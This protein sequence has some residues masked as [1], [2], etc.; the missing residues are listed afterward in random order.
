MSRTIRWGIVSTGRITHTFARDMVSVPG[1]TIQAVASRRQATAQDFAAQYG[2]SDVHGSYEDLLANPAVDAVYIATPHTLHHDNACAALRAGKAV[3]CEKPLTVN[4]A[5]AESLVAVAEASGGYLMEALWTWFLPAIRQ[6][7]AWVEAGRIGSLRHLKADFGYPLLPFDPDRREYDAQLGG[8]CLLEMGVYPVALD[9]LFHRRSPRSLQALGHFAPNGV[10]DDVT[11]LLDHGQSVSSLGT[12]FRCRL[13]NSATLV[14]DEGWI[15]IPDFFRAS[16]CRLFEL[17]DCV[18]H[19]QDER[20]TV[21]F[22]YQIEAV[23]EDLRA[24]RTQSAIVTHADSI[25]FQEQMEAVKA[26]LAASRDLPQ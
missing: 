16:E 18:E 25:A 23:Q 7:L 22:N 5:E 26:V 4:R 20:E 11:W 3:L 13:G 19:F 12:S 1:G 21:G 24:G 14:G 15:H 8:G 9:W 17:D 10:E 2:I 6:A